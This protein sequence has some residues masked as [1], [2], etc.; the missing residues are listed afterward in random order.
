VSFLAL[1]AS[2]SLAM[3]SLA[4]L[5][6]ANASSRP[7]SA[8]SSDKPC[9]PGPTS[10]FFGG[11]LLGS[12]LIFVSVEASVTIAFSTALSCVFDVRSD[13]G[14]ACIGCPVAASA[15]PTNGA[16]KADLSLVTP[17]ASTGPYGLPLLRKPSPRGSGTAHITEPS[18]ATPAGV[19][20]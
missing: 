6:M 10:A 15:A 8:G 13:A 14:S 20:L 7:S 12:I 2:F 4:C 11:V 18:R 1:L 3:N 5:T 9:P 19:L 17:L 16:S